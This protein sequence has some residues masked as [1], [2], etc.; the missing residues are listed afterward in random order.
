[1]AVSTP[2][3]VPISKPTSPGALPVKREKV[4][5]FGGNGNIGSELVHQLIQQDK[6]DI[7]IVSRGNKYFDSDTRIMPFVEHFIYDREQEDWSLEYCP[8]LMEYI[9]KYKFKFV[10]DF[11]AYKPEELKATLEVLDKKTDLY[12]YISSEL[13]YEVCEFRSHMNG[14]KSREIDAVRPE[15][16]SERQQL[17]DGDDYGNDKLLCEEVR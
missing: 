15:T 9:G 13:I 12:V 5:V 11:S 17:N 14:G 7:A 8:D 1:M 2:R 3:A 4:L 10:F 6:Y 16:K